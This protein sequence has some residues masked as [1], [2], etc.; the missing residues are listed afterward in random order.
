LDT[1]YTLLVR[2][3]RKQ[4]V[5]LAHRDHAYQHAVQ[6]GFSHAQVSMVY[7]AVNLLW[8]L[9]LALY[10]LNRPELGWGLLGLSALPLLA[11]AFYFK[12]G[13]KPN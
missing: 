6:S 5:Y 8:L 11:F 2:G 1:T 12:A 10:A 7:M 9:P 4:K 3:S 13:I